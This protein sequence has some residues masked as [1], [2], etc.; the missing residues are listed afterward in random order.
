MRIVLD[1]N[2]VISSYLSSQGASHKVLTSWRN[3]LFDLVVSEPILEEYSRA[4]QYPH[5]RKRH[6]LSDEEIARIVDLLRELAQVVTPRV[7][8]VVVDADPED[9]KII[10]CAV[11]GKADYIISGNDH[12]L[13]IKEYQSIQ[14]LT[15]AQFVLILEREAQGKAA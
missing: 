12:L 2:V 4:L 8:L 14:I 15:P 7:S 3:H 1:T 13:D 11:E 6:N 10:E 9:N 5:V